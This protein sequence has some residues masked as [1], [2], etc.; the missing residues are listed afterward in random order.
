MLIASHCLFH[1]IYHI[2]WFISGNSL[3][4]GF[5]RDAGDGVRQG[6]SF[7]RGEGGQEGK[8]ALLISIKQ[9]FSL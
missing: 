1:S 9:R 5:S 3:R 2:V 4:V 7:V 8:G 6:T